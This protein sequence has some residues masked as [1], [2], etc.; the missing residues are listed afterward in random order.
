MTV[1]KRIPKAIETAMGIRNW[2]CKENRAK[3][4]HASM[5]DSLPHPYSGAD[6]LVDEIHDHEG[7]VHRYARQRE[8]AEDGEIRGR[9]IEDNVAEEGT[10]HAEGH[11]EH[12]EKRLV[13]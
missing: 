13:K 2:D 10:D 12:Y 8:D 9:D 7:V 1:A 5:D 4:P 6:F 3:T 11:G